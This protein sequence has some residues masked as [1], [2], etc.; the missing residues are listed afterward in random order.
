MIHTIG[1]KIRNHQQ[2]VVSTIKLMDVEERFDIYFSRFFGLFFAKWG[3]ALSMSPTQVSLLSLFVGIPGG[4][5]FYYQDQPVIVAYGCLLVTLAGVLDSADG[6]LAR[7]TGTSSELG[8]KIDVI[9]DTFVFIAC[10]WGGALY[11][12]D[13]YGWWIIIIGHVAGYLHSAKS[14]NYDF[15][16][17]EYIYYLTGFDQAKIPTVEEVKERGPGKGF[18]GKVLYY[19]EIDYIRKQSQTKPRKQEARDVF[20]REA[21]G[22]NA[23]WF[24]KKY[25]ALNQSLMFWWAWICGTN[26]HR[27][28][29]MI[30]ALIGR[31][32]IY[33]FVCIGTYFPML[34]LNYFQTKRDNEILDSIAQLKS[35]EVE[36]AV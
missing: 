1:R 27:S 11:H 14:A 26:V 18:W 16:K 2:E 29:M 9:I 3:K 25:Q 12:F 8:R 7:L 31:F 35:S 15:Y 34:I 28:L 20:E 4:I 33:I 24:K 21:F 23:E 5:L 32:D 36:A 10:Y 6:Q 13:Y 17:T 19:L 30:F 22:E